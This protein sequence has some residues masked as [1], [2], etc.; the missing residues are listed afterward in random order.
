MSEILFP[1]EK[2][3][4]ISRRYFEGDT[5]R[6]FIGEVDDCDAN[7]VRVSGYAFVM[8]STSGFERK[9]EMRT[10][11]FPLADARIL[12]YVVPASTILD[13]AHYVIK[14]KRLHLTDDGDF[15]YDVDEFRMV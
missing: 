9:P 5:R 10:R 8:N 15:L 1:G 3:F 12:I 13:R 6:H 14:D 7:V 11:L 2:I 4:V